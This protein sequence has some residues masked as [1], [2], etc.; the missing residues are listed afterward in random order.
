MSLPYLCYKL[1]LYPLFHIFSG[2][3]GDIKESNP[4]VEKINSGRAGEMKYETSSCPVETGVIYS[5]WGSVAVGPLIAGIA[6]GAQ[7]EKHINLRY[8]SK[9]TNSDRDIDNI[10]ASTIAGNKSILFFFILHS[11]I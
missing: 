10:W 1:I 8:I 4:D 9:D 11:H 2:E 6:A 5:Q 7:P 3:K